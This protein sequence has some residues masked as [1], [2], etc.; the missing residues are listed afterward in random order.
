MHAKTLGRRG[1]GALLAILAMIT[2]LLVV[3]PATASAGET[4]CNPDYVRKDMI[5]WHVYPAGGDDTENIQC[6]IDEAVAYGAGAR[7]FLAEGTFYTD[8]IRAVD[9]Y[10]KFRGAGY[11]HTTIQPLEGGL[12]CVAAIEAGD[13]V[14]W[15]GFRSSRVMFQD[16]AMDIP[17]ACAEP[18]D[19][20]IDPEGFGFAFQD[21][22]AMVAVTDSRRAEGS[23]ACGELDHGALRLRKVNATAPFPDFEAP[24][25][26]PTGAFAAFFAG[27]SGTEGCDVNDPLMGKVRVVHSTIDGF[28]SPLFVD[29]WYESQLVFKNN[30]VGVTDVGIIGSH[31][32]HSTLRVLDNEM[33]SVAFTTVLV[34]ACTGT[35]VGEPT[36][37]SAMKVRVK[38]NVIHADGSEVGVVAFD[39][40]VEPGGINLRITDNEIHQYGSFAGIVN[41]GVDD[42]RIRRNH[43]VGEGV[44]GTFVEGVVNGGRII[45]NDMTGLGTLEAGILLGPDTSGILVKNNPGATVVDLGGNIVLGVIASANDFLGLDRR[46]LAVDR[47]YMNW[48]IAR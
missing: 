27:G 42:A 36:C 7:I 34:D 47:G 23:D 18:Y 6:A 39:E 13:A 46:G 12:D 30:T 17:L 20:F 3:L 43:H 16:L 10:G 38:D 11:D 29:N 14:T 1:L 21:F 40:L 15:W 41:L 31:L 26:N 32:E 24:V 22:F 37:A 9:F 8:W 19:E 4:E 2:T 25:F 35:A 44:F 5:G 45:G 48:T 33:T 28:G